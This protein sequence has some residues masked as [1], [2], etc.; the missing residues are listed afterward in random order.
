MKKIQDLLLYRKL[1][2][3]PKASQGG[4]VRLFLLILISP[5]VFKLSNLPPSKESPS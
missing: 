2:R 3:A 4:R 5:N 1:P